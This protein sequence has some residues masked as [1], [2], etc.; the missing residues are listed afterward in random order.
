MKRF[1]LI[2]ILLFTTSLYAQ[3]PIVE[4]FNVGTTWTY[5][6]GS[7]M[8]NYGLPENYATTNIGTTPYPNNT[9]VNITSPIYN[10]TNCIGIMTVTFPISGFIETT[11]DYLYFQYRIGLGAWITVQ[12]F[13]G[14]Q[15]GTFLYT[16]IPKTATQFRYRLR[17]DASL[18]IWY[19]TDGLWDTYQHG[20][21]NT[22]VNISNVYVSSY[23]PIVTSVYYY[24]IANFVITCSSVLPVELLDFDVHCN[25]FIWVTATEI[26]NDYFTIYHSFDGYTWSYY[27][28]YKGSGST[29]VPTLYE[30]SDNTKLNGYYKLSQTDYNGVSQDLDI[31]YI[32]CSKNIDKR[33]NKLYNILGQEVLPYTMGIIFILYDDNTSAKIYFNTKEQWRQYL[34]K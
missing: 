32:K 15:N 30:I 8:Q 28:T 20:A 31:R 22:E 4:E 7:G 6:N 27:N 3:F 23:N 26:N 10:L 34:L 2:V 11:Y 1:Y 19:S 5:T 29:N 14:V 33:I 9:T 12:S 24:D 18:K 17:T 16:T 25:K 21:Y 13:T